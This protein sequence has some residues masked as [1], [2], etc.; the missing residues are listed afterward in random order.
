MCY[1]YDCFS[2]KAEKISSILENY[3]RLMNDFYSK[4]GI[5]SLVF[6]RDS[7]IFGKVNVFEILQIYF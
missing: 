3:L 4:D 1:K 7:L 5:Y 2:D 6:I